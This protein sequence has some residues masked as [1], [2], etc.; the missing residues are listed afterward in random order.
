MLGVNPRQLSSAD[1][2]EVLL[3]ADQEV[4]CCPE[5]FR[6]VRHQRSV[7]RVIVEQRLKPFIRWYHVTVDY[8][9]PAHRRFDPDEHHYIHQALQP[10]YFDVRRTGRHDVPMAEICMGCTLSAA[11][12]GRLIE[13]LKLER[14]CAAEVKT[15]L[16]RHLRKVRNPVMAHCGPP[17]RLNG[18][19]EFIPTL[20]QIEG[21]RIA[22]ATRPID[23]W[24]Q[25]YS[26]LATDLTPA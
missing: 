13:L 5:A 12:Q 21:R 19:G 15:A 1:L 8:D 11:C 10:E 18:N 14:P 16:G 9:D 2:I 24:S 23:R 3:D 22:N 25:E 20:H 17:F 6:S 4:G 7:R 26:F